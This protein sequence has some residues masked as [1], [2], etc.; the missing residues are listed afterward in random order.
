MPIVSYLLMFDVKSNY[1]VLGHYSVWKN[2]KS[3]A[4]ITTR[5]ISTFLWFFLLNVF[6]G[7]IWWQIWVYF[8]FEAFLTVQWSPKV[9]CP[10]QILTF[11]SFLPVFLVFLYHC[12]HL[13][14]NAPQC[15]P[16]HLFYSFSC[17]K[18]SKNWDGEVVYMCVKKDMGSFMLKKL[19][20]YKISSSKR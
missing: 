10:T 8:D 1:A 15:T 2:Q 20:F 16:Q 13:A 7:Y 6:F 14:Q 9:E 4:K 5:A 12:G 3:E 18:I 17:I 19:D 11:S